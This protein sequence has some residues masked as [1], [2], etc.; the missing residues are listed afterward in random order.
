[1]DMEALLS[2]GTETVSG[3]HLDG[4]KRSCPPNYTRSSMVRRCHNE[5]VAGCKQD[6]WP[7]IKDGR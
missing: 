6:Y 5:E 1:M 3:I 2:T 7:N 4:E